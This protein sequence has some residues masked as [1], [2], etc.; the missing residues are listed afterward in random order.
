MNNFIKFLNLFGISVSFDSSP[1]LLFLY[2]IL[3]FAILGLFSFIN[4]GVY[5]GILY[6]FNKNNKRLLDRLSKW[7]FLLRILDLYK[8]TRIY[9][10]SALRLRLFYFYFV[11]VL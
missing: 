6:I 2:V 10:I 1:I 8:N 4:I 7:C 5:L 9:F 11:S 3:C